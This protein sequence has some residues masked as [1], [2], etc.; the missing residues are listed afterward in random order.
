[1][2]QTMSESI[3]AAIGR[4]VSGLASARAVH[5]LLRRSSGI[6]WE[7]EGLLRDV[8]GE[9]REQRIALLED[10][11]SADV[12]LDELRRA[13][14]EERL[15]MLPVERV[16][17][18]DDLYSCDDLAERAGVDRDTLRADLV[19]LGFAVPD[20][21]DKVFDDDDLAV[22]CAIAA[23][24]AAGLDGD[25]FRA[26]GRVIGQSLSTV[27]AAVRDLAAGRGLDPGGGER[28]VGVRYAEL[29]R[30]L[31][32]QIQALVAQTLRVHLR[33][34]VRDDVV[35]QVERRTGRL[36]QTVE[37]TVAFADLTGFT[38]LGVRHSPDRIARIADRFSELVLEASR[39]RARPVKFLGD[40]AMLIAADPSCMLDTAL[41][42][43]SSA[44]GDGLPPVRVGV[45][46]GDVIIRRGDVFGTTANVAARLCELAEPG[47][48]LA[49]EATRDA[50]P[51]PDWSRPRRER[52][53]GLDR[54]VRVSSLAYT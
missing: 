17:A 46:T 5:R 10:L 30:V 22:A 38:A 16:L 42:V 27:A 3:T 33:A 19:N 44:D 8:E 23:F 51:R 24:R 48:L 43:V 20:G 13:V 4:A 40:G 34:G 6:D 25:G 18:G 9:D 53:K 7:A 54:R 14:A 2:Q 49:D 50:C 26:A 1:M 28:D 31:T 29:A 52:L 41:E 39:E 11:A 15:A 21:D 32:P 35:G 36:E 47:G 37:R 12:P 45:A